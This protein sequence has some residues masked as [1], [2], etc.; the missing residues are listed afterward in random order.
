MD[1]TT[2][3]ITATDGKF[4]KIGTFIG[5]QLFLAPNAKNEAYSLISE[6]EKDAFET[7]FLALNEE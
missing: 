1:N 3:H 2:N 7:S 6:E 4:I 5:T